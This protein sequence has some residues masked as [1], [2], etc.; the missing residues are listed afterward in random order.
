MGRRQ[1]RDT[2]CQGQLDPVREPGSF[3]LSRRPWHTSTHRLLLNFSS[4]PTHFRPCC[5]L[6]CQALGLECAYFQCAWE[7]RGI[8]LWMDKE[9]FG[10]QKKGTL[11]NP[12]SPFH[13]VFHSEWGEEVSPTK[14]TIFWEGGVLG[15]LPLLL[16]GV[17]H[18]VFLPL[19]A[20]HECYSRLFTSNPLLAIPQILVLLPGRTPPFSA[21]GRHALKIT[22]AA[23][24]E[25]IM[26]YKILMYSTMHVL[27][28]WAYN[29]I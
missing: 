23:R 22:G 7:H 15:H 14:R 6:L 13:K 25:Q 12:V 5:W 28:W 10:V 17:P 2:H 8:S 19:S 3:T 20:R 4:P 16:L 9:W 24:N 11:D 1:L 27:Y 21:K 26:C 29:F 18:S